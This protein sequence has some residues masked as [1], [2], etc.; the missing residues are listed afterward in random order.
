MGASRPRVL[1]GP[2]FLAKANDRDGV[3][4]IKHRTQGSVTRI[5]ILLLFPIAA[6]TVSLYDDAVYVV[7][8]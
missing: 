1:E 2:L 7:F 4:S 8:G 5:R 6:H 3:A